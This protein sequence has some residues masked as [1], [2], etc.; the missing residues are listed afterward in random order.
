MAFHFALTEAAV[1]LVEYGLARTG[2]CTVVATGGV[3]CNQVLT[4]LLTSRLKARGINLFC[5]RNLPPNDGGISVGQA[6]IA[7]AKVRN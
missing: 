5:H 3:F 4:H 2:P 6:A 7:G 1:S